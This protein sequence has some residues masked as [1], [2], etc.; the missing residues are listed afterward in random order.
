MPWKF[1]NPI[2]TPFSRFR[3]FLCNLTGTGGANMDAGGFPPF[4]CATPTPMSGGAV[5]CV[6]GKRFTANGANP[7]A[8]ASRTTVGVAVTNEDDC[9]N[10]FSATGNDAGSLCF[11]AGTAGS[12]GS[13]PTS[14]PNYQLPQLSNSY[15]PFYPMAP[16]GRPTYLS[17]SMFRQDMYFGYNTLAIISKDVVQMSFYA[18][19]QVLAATNPSAT[20]QGPS[21]KAI[22][23]TSVCI[24][25]NVNNCQID[26]TLICN[27]KSTQSPF[28]GSN[29]CPTSVNRVSTVKGAAGIPAPALVTPVTLTQR[30]DGNHHDYPISFLNVYFIHLSHI[31]FLYYPYARYLFVDCQSSHQPKRIQGCLVPSAQDLT[32]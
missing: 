27:P 14:N 13:N 23:D 7:V 16:A 30:I 9:C 29:A 26:F 1:V 25:G 24:N 4:T 8:C 11:P 15:V 6:A 19:A 5:S 31:P 2:F 17:G 18:T 10:N 28:T 3:L 21:S 12:F 22:V 32:C 20:Y